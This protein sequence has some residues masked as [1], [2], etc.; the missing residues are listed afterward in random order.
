MQGATHFVEICK[1]INNGKYL[2][3]L[4]S[5]IKN[6]QRN[7]NLTRNAASLVTITVWVGKYKDLPVTE[8]ETTPS[9]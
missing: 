8:I 6:L 7:L 3:Y 1:D 4:V 5:E 2:K 9:C